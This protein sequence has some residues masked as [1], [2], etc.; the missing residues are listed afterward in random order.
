MVNAILGENRVIV[1]PIV[2]TTRDAI[3]LKFVPAGATL[4]QLAL[5]GIRCRGCEPAKLEKTAE[6]RAYWAIARSDVVLF[7][8]NAVLRIREQ[9][10]M[11]AGYAHVPG[12]GIII[13]V[14]C[15]DTLA[16]HNRTKL[17]LANLIR[18]EFQYLDTAP[19]I[20]V[21]ACTHQR[22]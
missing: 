13:V 5:A 8:L 6:L 9:D 10:K 4:Q 1:S 18:Q 11:L 15:W 21:S 17:H 14:N 19:I 3:A 16:M 7:E 2:R 20:F 12:R 22:Y